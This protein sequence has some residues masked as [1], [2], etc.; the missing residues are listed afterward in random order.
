MEPAKYEA[1]VRGQQRRDQARAAKLALA[2]RRNPEL[3]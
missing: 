3:Q 1:W 2:E